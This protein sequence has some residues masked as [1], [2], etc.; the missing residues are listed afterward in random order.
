MDPRRATTWAT[1][2][3]TFA[4]TILLIVLAEAAGAR[5]ITVHWSSPDPSTVTGFRV[6]TRAASQPYGTPAYDG[7]PTAVDGVYSI[8]LTVSDSAGTYVVT[9]A[10]NS[11]GESALSNEML[12]T[13]PLCG[14]AVV[15]SGEACDD[16][17]A[18]AWDGWS[19]TW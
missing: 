15:E 7:K 16:G 2:A 5:I 19:E 17:N 6:Y 4:L 1:F 13:S 3:T 14:N 8:P 12:A 11:A 18:T 10:Y 9:T